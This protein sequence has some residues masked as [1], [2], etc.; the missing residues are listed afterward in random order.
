MKRTVFI[1]KTFKS[2]NL[3]KLQ[4]SLQVIGILRLVYFHFLTIKKINLLFQKL[5]KSI[6]EIFIRHILPLNKIEATKVISKLE[7]FSII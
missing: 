5:K 3:E 4:F 7:K 1:L 2:Q 6:E